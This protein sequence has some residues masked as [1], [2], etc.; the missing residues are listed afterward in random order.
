MTRPES[1]K[2]PPEEQLYLDEVAAAEV[3][4]T[5]SGARWLLWILF[6]FIVIM[7]VWANWAEL[8][9]VTVAQGSVIPSS[10]LQVVQ[11]LEGGILKKVYVKEGQQVNPGQKL[12]L[13]DDTRFRSDLRTRDQEVVNLEGDVTRLRAELSGIKINKVEHG[14]WRDQFTISFA[15]LKFSE[16]FIKKYP[17]QAAQQQALFQEQLQNLSNRIQIMGRQ[18]EQQE[19]VTLEHKAAVKTLEQSIELLQEEIGITS[20][21]AEEGLVPQVEFLK[22]RRQLNEM[23]GELVAKRLEA[24]KIQSSL[25]EAILKRR[26]V[27]LEFRSKVQQEL[28]EKQ[29]KLKQLKEGQIGLQDRVKRTLVLSPVKG[30]IQKI[31]INTVGGVI[32]P[33]MDL[34]EIVPVEDTLL[35]EARVSPRDIAFIRPGLSAVVKFT[36]YDFT[37]YG[38]LPGKVEHISA[39][40]FQDEKGNPYFLVRV[41]TDLNY[42]GSEKQPL[43]II[44]GMQA[45][46]DIMT[47]K[48]RVIDYLLKPILRAKQSALRER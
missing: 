38:G 43:P 9:E 23:Q 28:S 45:S 33:G 46:V 16:D 32:Q 26:N 1:Q 10:R 22:L 24:N 18:I 30:T 15:H 36:A 2:I 34:I 35:V 14:A 31:N 27:V 42:L 3:S 29:A 17:Q 44:P 21:L 25:Y 39:D 5:A 12:L 7:L 13:I 11:N 48:K 19:Q 6:V 20:P 40:S 37:I 41:R 47:G 4:Y 8:D